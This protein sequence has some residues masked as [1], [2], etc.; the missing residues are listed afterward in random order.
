MKKI[1]IL[2]L[3]CLCVSTVYGQEKKKVAIFESIGN[4]V[5]EDVKGAILDALGEGIYNSNKYILLERAN[6]AQLLKEYDFQQSGA[7]D[8]EQLLEIGKAAGADYACYASVR[9]IGINYRIAYRLVEVST[10]AIEFSGSKSTQKG[11]NDLLDVI[12]AI[13]EEM[14][15]D[16]NSSNVKKAIT[17]EPIQKPAPTVNI[18]TENYATL[19]IYRPGNFVGSLVSYQITLNGSH[20]VSLSNKSKADIKVNKEGVAIVNAG[21]LFLNVNIEFG[22][23]YFIRVNPN[24]LQLK[25][26]EEGKKEYDKI[27]KIK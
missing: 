1:F 20:A 13:A 27:T 25:S 24:S 3:I 2:L 9:K 17:Q 8:D 26:N 15:T 11:V 10:A 12:N 19:H 21:S 5:D 22:K 16:K 4:A 18:N 14:F 7:V 23:E 6:Y